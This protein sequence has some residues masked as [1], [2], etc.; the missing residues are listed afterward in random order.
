MCDNY[1]NLTMDN[2]AKE[3]LCCAISDKKHQLGVDAKRSWLAER[4]LEGHIFRKLDDKGKV[5]IEY[6]PLETAWVPVN[7]ENYIYIY[8]FWVSG[9]F[10]SKG[11][12]RKLLEYCIK[13]AKSRDKSGI[14]VISSKK[15]TPF[16]T[17]KKYMQKY[18]FEVVD[19][20]G[21]E[22]ELLALSFDGSKPAFTNSAHIQEIDMKE[23]TIFYG[24]QCPYI[25]NC[26]EQVEKF[27]KDNN[28][29]LNLIEVDTHEKAKA[30]PCVFN[31]WA[32]FYGGRFKT[33]HLLN[34]GYLKKMFLGVGS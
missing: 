31:N 2:L 34:E 33:V 25:P 15:K 27:C 29:P 4:F 19:R 10:K 30:V 13:D 7:G 20:I 16:L 11:H 9:S 8:C 28:I 18:G 21:S 14:C 26:I 23:L 5:F 3:H 1:I 6:T 32:V 17:D 22:Y 24:K 12:G